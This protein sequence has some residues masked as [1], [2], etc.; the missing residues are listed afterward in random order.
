MIEMICQNKKLLERLAP[1]HGRDS[2]VLRSSRLSQA[3]MLYVRSPEL[4]L[5]P[6]PQADPVS[7]DGAL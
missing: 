6:R 1:E 7:S 2:E 4:Y 5:W 3:P